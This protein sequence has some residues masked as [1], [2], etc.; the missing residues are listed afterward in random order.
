MRKV[1]EAQRDDKARRE[2]PAR[3]AI[4]RRIGES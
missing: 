3:T 4:E 2:E 1:V